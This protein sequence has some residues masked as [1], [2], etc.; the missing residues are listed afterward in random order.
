[1]RQKRVFSVNFSIT[2]KSGEE[3]LVLVRRLAPAPAP[4]LVWAR[5][6]GCQ[7]HGVPSAPHLASGRS[8]RPG[9]W[10]QLHPG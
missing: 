9:S 6:K 3:R 1:M 2:A 4:A 8:E 10:R 5:L 7:W